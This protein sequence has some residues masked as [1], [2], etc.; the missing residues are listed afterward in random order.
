MHHDVEQQNSSI[1]MK[2]DSD[3][4]LK[5]HFSKQILINIKTIN[6]RLILTI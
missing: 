6:F 4:L 5:Y 3:E 2:N 1:I